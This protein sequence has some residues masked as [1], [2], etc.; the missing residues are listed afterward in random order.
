[1]GVNAISNNP[2]SILA[3]DRNLEVGGLPAKP[4]LLDL[5]L[6]SR[7]GWSEEL[8]Y[9]KSTSTAGGNILFADGHV[10]FLKSK[11]LNSAFQTLGSVTNR[12]AVP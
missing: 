3:G 12:F 10:E 1:V 2:N 5:T 7:V 11:Q 6:K 9:K 4:G 8:H